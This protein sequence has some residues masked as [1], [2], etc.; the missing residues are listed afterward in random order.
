MAL[1]TTQLDGKCAFEYAYELRD[2]DPDIWAT[3]CEYNVPPHVEDIPRE[4]QRRTVKSQ[5]RFKEISG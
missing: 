3:F 2:T 4:V 5:G 1:I